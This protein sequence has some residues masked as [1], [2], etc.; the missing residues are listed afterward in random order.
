MIDTSV[1]DTNSISQSLGM[2]NNS[3][4]I[5]STNNNSTIFSNHNNTI[6]PDRI[7]ANFSKEWLA[8]NLNSAE[9]CYTGT[10]QSGTKQSG[11][12]DSIE[13][14]KLAKATKSLGDEFEVMVGDEFLKVN[15]DLDKLWS[16]FLNGYFGCVIPE[17]K[18]SEKIVD[19]AEENG[20]ENGWEMADGKENDNNGH[21][22][23]EA[24]ID[25]GS[26]YCCRKNENGPERA[27]L[28]SKALGVYSELD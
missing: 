11:T 21:E 4:S 25:T 15:G 8:S 6:F 13:L 19:E 18:R 27:K 23:V 26:R 20:D 16:K 22:M 17:G 28:K 3:T 7:L 5:N 10:K 24:L 12:D 9:E 1:I 14:K 2:N